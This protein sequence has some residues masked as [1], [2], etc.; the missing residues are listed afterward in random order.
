MNLKKSESN[1]EKVAEHEINAMGR[2]TGFQQ[3]QK[4]IIAVG[5]FVPHYL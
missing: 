3:Q 5:S 2:V 1:P 4:Q